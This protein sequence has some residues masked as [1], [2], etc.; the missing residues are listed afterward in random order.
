MS[1]LGRQLRDAR[2]AKGLSLDDVQEMTKIR[3]RYL[4]AI[5]AGD[6]KVLP[7]SFYVRAFIKTY[8][9]AVGLSAD[10][11]LQEHQDDVPETE[12]E[13][14]M[15]P[16]VQQRRAARRTSSSGG[17]SG[18]WLSTTLMWIFPLLIVVLVYIFVVRNDNGAP[19]VASNNKGQQQ[20]EATTKPTTTTTPPATTTPESTTTTPESTTTTPPT[21]AGTEQEQSTPDATGTDEEATDSTTT[22]TDTASQPVVTQAGKEG[23]NTIFNV[24]YTGTTPL[25]VNIKATGQSWLEVY[26]SADSSGERL[27]FNNTESGQDLSYDLGDTGLY[28]KS[29]NS[30]ATDI[31]INGQPITDGKATSRIVL[32]LVKEAATDTSTDSTSTSTDSSTDATT[33]ESTSTETSGN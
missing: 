12:T 18:K 1:D 33:D 30:P 10:E 20:Q 8:A 28:I 26:K 29:G 16:V 15:E 31:T 21:G 9:E 14:V 25:K 7:G 23:R 13:A 27:F 2:L 24:N 19:E 4:E 5:E 11:L 22:P 3:K 6:F 32:K 17:R